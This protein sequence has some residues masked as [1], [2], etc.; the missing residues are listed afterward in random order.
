MTHTHK[1]TDPITAAQRYTYRSC[2]LALLTLLKSITLQPVTGVGSEKVHTQHHLDHVHTNVTTAQDKNQ[3][4]RWV[5]CKITSCR[6]FGLGL[7]NAGQTTINHIKAMQKTNIMTPRSAYYRTNTHIYPMHKHTKQNAPKR[8][9]CHIYKHILQQLFN[10]PSSFEY[11][12]SC[13]C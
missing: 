5:V 2:P 9:H 7:K 11:T 3:L 10:F 8:V 13:S 12:N 6:Q 1:H 4:Q